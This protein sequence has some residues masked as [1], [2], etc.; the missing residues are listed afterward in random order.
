LKNIHVAASTI[1]TSTPVDYQRKADLRVSQC[2]KQL[3][4]FGLH[5]VI[6]T[7]YSVIPTG[8][9]EVP[10]TYS[11]APTDY[12]EALTIYSVAPTG[13]AGVPTRYSVIPTVYAEVPTIYS[14]IPTLVGSTARELGA[15]GKVGA[16][17]S[18]QVFI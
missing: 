7:R 2:R 3:S 11:V 12:A 4:V 5:A 14:I 1:P 8:Y 17:Q 18:R 13:Y 6:P 10:T 15:A 16:K 9:A